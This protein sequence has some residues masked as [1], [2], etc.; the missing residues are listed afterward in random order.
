MHDDFFELGGH[1]LLAVRLISAVRKAFTVEMPI[2]DVFDYPTIALLAEQIEKKSSDIVIPS[3][4]I[5]QSRPERIPLSFSQERLWF[6]DQLEGSV[7]YHIT[8]ILRLKGKLNTEALCYSLQQIINRHEI[9]RTTIREDDGQA[10]QYINS[11]DKWEL[12]TIENP[13]DIENAKSLERYIKQIVNRPFDLANDHM[14]RA[15]LIKLRDQ[16]HILIITLHHIASDGW[17]ASVIVKE[18]VELWRA[19]EENRRPFLPEL[20]LQYADFAMWQRNYI[21]GEVLEKKLRFWRENLQGVQPL[22]LPTDYVRPLMQSTKGAFSR[23]TVDKE[24]SDAIKQLAQKEGA[25]LFMTLLAAFKVLLFRY[26]GQSDI[27]VGTPIAGRQQQELEGLIGFFVNTLALR[28]ELTDSISFR[29]LLQQVRANTLKAYEHQEVPFEKVVETVVKER[30]LSRSPLF[31][32]MFILQNTPE[33]DELHLKEMELIREVKEHDT[34][35]FELTFSIT[36]SPGGMNGAVEYC[37]DLF[38]DQTIQR[39]IVHFKELLNSVIKDPNRDIATLPMLTVSEEQELLMSFNDT[40][41]A[42]PEEKSIIDLFEEQVE[43]T[44]D[45]QAVVFENKSITYYQL[46]T[47]SNQLAHYLRTRGVKE[48]TLVP[49]S[50]ERRIE[51]VIGVLAILKAGGAYVPVD[52]DYPVERIVYMIEDINANLILSSKESRVNI[53]NAEQ[54]EILELDDDWSK[55]ED[56]QKIIRQAF[57][58]LIICNTF[59][60]PLVQQVGQKA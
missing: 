20:P 54:I 51:M 29:E 43:K 3:I 18:L 21:Q 2:G 42:F 55:I 11:K 50:I 8:S 19:Y 48:N 32:V 10:Y 30:Q 14:L 46:N 47:R 9:L 23:F 39:M 44:P 58:G 45:S 57:I 53:R 12:H 40:A 26:S 59:F 15:D 60:I 49:I 37:S 6:I 22:E 33:I 34:T 35:K 7:Q 5:V 27:C 38:N 52:P 25:S 36:E 16:E 17:S 28:S 13:V 24:I 4:E 1:S 56:N 41:K 31:Q